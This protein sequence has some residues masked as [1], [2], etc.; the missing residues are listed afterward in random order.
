MAMERYQQ[1]L[2]DWRERAAVPIAVAAVRLNGATIWIGGSRAGDADDRTLEPRE[3]RFP[4]YSITK[5]FT[6]VCV[7]RLAQAG[8]LD[9]DGPVKRW[10]DEVPVPATL[11]ISQLLRH[12]GGLPDYGGLAAYHESVRRTPSTPWTDEQFLSRTMTNGLLFQ[13]GMGWSYSNVGYLLLRRIIERAGGSGFRDCIDQHIVSRLNLRDTFVAESIDDWK[14]CVPGFG[15]EVAPDKRVVDIR[16]NYHPGWCAPGVAVSTVED[17]TEFYDALFRGEL[18]DAKELELMLRLVRVP[19]SHPP[20]VT[21]SSGMG[22]LADPDGPFGPSYGHGG[23]GP[24][25]SLE[26]SVLPDTKVGR[27]SVAVACNSSMG[28]DVYAA[29]HGLLQVATAGA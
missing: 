25:Y 21:P 12:T 2:D 4:I 16:A 13:P 17:V 22:I 9:V 20:V 3:F 28:P 24:G 27:V 14:V 6:A 1:Q 5:S 18:L 10:L 15:Q 8:L 23:R 19:G 11:S 29:Q 26:A 7:L